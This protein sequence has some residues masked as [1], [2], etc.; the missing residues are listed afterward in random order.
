MNIET[1]IDGQP[2]TFTASFD[3]SPNYIT[4]QDIWRAKRTLNWMLS[5]PSVRQL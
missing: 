3:Y 5:T 4:G 1:T 2:V